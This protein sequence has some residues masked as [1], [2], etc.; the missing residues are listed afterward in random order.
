MGREGADVREPH[1]KC[2]DFTKNSFSYTFD[3]VN[4]KILLYASHRLVLSVVAYIF[5]ITLA[6]FF[7]TAYLLSFIVGPNSPPLTLKSFGRIV[8]FLIFAALLGVS[9]LTLKLKQWDYE[10][11]TMTFFLQIYI[12]IIPSTDFLVLNQKKMPSRG[13]IRNERYHWHRSK[14]YSDVFIN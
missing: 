2:R 1:V 5:S 14:T 11:W 13:K 12:L 10:S 6:Y 4:K 3:F 9:L 7:S 8:N